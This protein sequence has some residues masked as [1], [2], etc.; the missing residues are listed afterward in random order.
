MGIIVGVLLWIFVLKSGV[1]ATLA[2]VFLAMCIPLKVGKN[3]VLDDLEHNLHPWVYYSVI[4]LFALSNT[5]IPLA[6]VSFE[7][8]L[9]PIS[10]EI[11]LGLFIGKQ[12]GVFSFSWIAIKL[13]FAKL[14]TGASWIQLYGVSVLTGVGFTMS[15]LISSLAF[16]HSSGDH[17][18]MDRIGI[19]IGSLL[20]GILA[21]A[22]LFFAGKSSKEKCLE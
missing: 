12:L 22:V 4:P 19:L 1:H 15:L 20:S 10:L 18:L 2:G 3:T 14:P 6:G 5:G 16:E 8:L 17:V 11:I 13:G 7:A 21:Y 9:E